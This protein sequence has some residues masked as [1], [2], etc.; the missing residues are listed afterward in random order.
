MGRILLVCR[1]AGRD[2]RR[3]LAGAALLLLA[4]T[5][6]TATLT[7]GLVLH[8]AASQPYEH[9]RE[10]TA[11]PDV[12][13]SDAP[14]GEGQGAALAALEALVKAPEV[15]DYSGPYPH[16]RVIAGA[17]DVTAP[18]WAQGR[19]ADPAPVDRPALTEGGWVRD[20]G[21]VLEATL[22][23]AF[24]VGAGDTVTLDGRAFQVAGVAVTAAAWPYPKACLA[25]CV[26][27]AAEASEEE[28]EAEQA[29][30]PPAGAP[31][32]GFEPAGGGVLSGIQG[33]LVWLTKADARSLV[34]SE[35]SLSYAVY[36]KL[37][38]PA[39]APAFVNAHLRDGV[40]PAYGPGSAG[41]SIAD[42]QEIRAGHS[43]LVEKRRN[44]LLGGSWLL[45][46]LALAS[47]TVLVG[48][49]MADQVRHVGL[50]KAVGGT[51]SL[52]A[53]VLLAEHVAVAL[54][55]TGPDWRWA[56]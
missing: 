51:P 8:G 23:E 29:G 16:T 11:G 21:V 15:V 43:W 4:I 48:G 7:L 31:G 45:G 17:G 47:I 13:A 49:R 10:S 46:L 28:Q 32:P 2:L 9:T 34:P 26:F 27:G 52:V 30:P 22:A 33:G 39:D 5:A 38:D 18:V 12:V 44:A 40:D 25:P 14:F 3:H 36:L 55:A 53:A 42:W 6:A 56:C 19:D 20:G 24:G 41:W 35:E 1:L 54:L 37:A 50:L